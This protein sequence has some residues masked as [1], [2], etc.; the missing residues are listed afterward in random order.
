MKRYLT[1]M[2]SSTLE[3]RIKATVRSDTP[4]I[5]WLE[6][7][8]AYRVKLDT[9]TEGHKALNKRFY[10]AKFGSKSKALKAAIEYRDANLDPF[11]LQ[12][13]QR[14]EPPKVEDDTAMPCVQKDKRFKPTLHSQFQL[15]HTPRKQQP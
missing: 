3:S 13:I 11:R 12:H 10:V 7:L 6:S 4:Y 1:T 2:K 9:P 14:R 8:S 5:I 15:W